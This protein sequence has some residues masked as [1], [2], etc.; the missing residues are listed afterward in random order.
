MVALANGPWR[1]PADPASAWAVVDHGLALL[2]AAA[3]GLDPPPDPPP[4]APDP[5]GDPEPPA[6]AAAGDLPAELA[7]LA[8]T[9]A[10]FNPWI[11]QVVVRPAGAGLVLVWPG[12]DT[13][14]LTPL[15][16]GGFRLGDDPA[17]PDRVHFTAMVEGRPMRAVVSGWPY[18]RVD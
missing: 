17:S 8:G 14:P 1:S 3:L 2:R 16:G 10:A 18:D 9:Y 11:P 7:P 4:V 13:E 6:E 15:P 5:A 12:D